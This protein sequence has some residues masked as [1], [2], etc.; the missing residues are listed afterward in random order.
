MQ[1]VLLWLL[2][3]GPALLLSGETRLTGLA[4]AAFALGFIAGEEQALIRR[5]GPWTRVSLSRGHVLVRG[6]VRNGLTAVR[7][8]GAA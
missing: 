2:L 6:T 8:T 1:Y 7:T 5:N 4:F 3:A